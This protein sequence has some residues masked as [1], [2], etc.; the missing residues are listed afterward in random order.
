VTAPRWSR[1][2]ADP[3]GRAAALGIA[4]AAALLL[5]LAPGDLAPVAARGAV[6]VGGLGALVTLARGRS[7]VGPAPGGLAVLEARPLGRDAGL[8]I[9]EIG[10]RRLLV[11]FGP[12]GVQLLSEI[13]APPESRP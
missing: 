11:G 5:A 6:A 1:L 13:G 4:A 7:R 2:L 12:N 3:R 9:V 10:G 8:A